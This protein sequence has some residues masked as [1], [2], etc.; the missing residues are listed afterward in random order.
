MVCLYLG[1]VAPD[2]HCDV[3]CDD[4]ETTGQQVCGDDGV[5]YGTVSLFTL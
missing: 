2:Y 5:T 4:D 3:I 1:A